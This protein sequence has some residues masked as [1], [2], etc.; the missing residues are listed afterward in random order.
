LNKFIPYSY[1]Y[2][3]SG[4][5]GY[6]AL[7]ICSSMDCDIFTTV[8]SEE[9]KQFLI[10]EFPKLKPNQIFNSRDTRFEA[11]ILNITDGYGVDVILNS[12]SGD[13]LLSSVKCLAKNGRFCEIGKYDMTIN[14]HLG[15]FILLL[16]GFILSI[17]LLNSRF[18]T[19]RRE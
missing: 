13:K 12:L 6:A 9:K 1:I 17:S 11:N 18:V 19:D 15:I 3:G 5:V 2:S 8:G 16:N 10:K 14:S 4:G 7:R